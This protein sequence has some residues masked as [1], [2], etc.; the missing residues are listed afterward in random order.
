MK[1]LLVNPPWFVNG[2]YGV[3]AGSRWPHVKNETERDYLPFP[4][5]LAYSASLLEKEGF[6]VDLID[7]V[8][9]ELTEDDF[10]KKILS[11]SP[12]IL[13]S[14]IS[15]PS[16]ENDLRILSKIPSTIRL[17]LCGLDAELLSSPDLLKQY[18]FVSAAISG[19]YEQ[20][21]LQLMKTF[22][23]ENLSQQIAGVIL[24][25]NNYTKSNLSVSLSDVN[26]LPWPHRTSL[27]MRK[28]VDAPGGLPLPNAQM[29]ASRG[30]PFSCHFCAWPQ[31]MGKPG[32]Y[33]PRAVED[34]LNE[35][36]FLVHHM[37]F[38]SIYFDD[39]TFNVGIPRML[40]FS[41]KLIDRRKRGKILV[42]WAIMAR[43]DLMTEA[44]LKQL[45]LA[46]LYS[47][48]YGVE[49]ADQC[50]LDACGKKMNLEKTV[51]MIRLTQSMGIKVHLTFI[52]GL[53]NETKESLQKTMD[54]AL[55]LN[56]DSLQFS[57]A[58]PFPGTALYKSLQAEGRLLPYT[59]KNLDGNHDYVIQSFSL[60][61]EDIVHARD[62]AYTRWG[63]H[64]RLQRNPKKIGL[65]LWHYQRAKTYWKQY[66]FK[67]LVFKTCDYLKFLFLFNRDIDKHRFDQIASPDLRL[68][69]IHSS[70]RLY[71]GEKEITRGAGIQCSFRHLGMRYDTSLCNCKINR[72]QPNEFYVEFDYFTQNQLTLK[73]IFW[74]MIHNRTKIFWKADWITRHPLTL[75]DLKFSLCLTDEY[76]HWETPHDSSNFPAIEDWETFFPRQC[77]FEWIRVSSQKNIL[78]S[79]TYNY[80]SLPSRF[81]DQI[82][83]TGRHEYGR[84]I[85]ALSTSEVHIPPGRTQAFSADL[86]FNI[87][88]NFT[89]KR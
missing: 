83:N 44:V 79:L 31:I 67:N 43:A 39:D 85:H 16:R 29:W 40:E 10:L 15:T 75:T 47:V 56:P 60:S 82:Q 53:P 5:Y 70:I 26:S 81:K 76:D 19:E 12:D 38:K 54:L 86:S 17:V 69:I 46:G 80:F 50:L 58:T 72:I 8:A 37:K 25:E 4:F 18:S 71:S 6:T 23:S 22:K 59:P 7:A 45:K 62:E 65:G 61:P 3:R 14:E 20:S 49:S 73:Q 11:F 9:S 87:S 27:P 55:S 28:Y 57:I 32:L 41:Q 34:I 68:H 52:L 64:Q 74:F 21:L 77:S 48:K 33:R 66:G 78:P 30:C 51:E 24:K 84:M 88:T 63:E 13:V 1:I 89:R 36:H 2:Y 35:M 42:P